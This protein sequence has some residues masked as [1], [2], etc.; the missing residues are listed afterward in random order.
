MRRSIVHISG[1]P[2]RVADG[3]VL[4]ERQNIRDLELA[5]ERWAVA[6]RDGF[7]AH[8]RSPS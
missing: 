3:C 2:H 7:D 5:A 8:L 1:Q 4:D 6:L